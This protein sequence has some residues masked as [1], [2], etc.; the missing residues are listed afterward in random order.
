MSQSSLIYTIVGLP[1]LMLFVALDGEQGQR[2]SEAVGGAKIS[3]VLLLINDNVIHEDI[4]VMFC[5]YETKGKLS[6]HSY[7][8]CIHLD[9]NSLILLI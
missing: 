7:D 6:V 2:N 1:T 8:L 9:I 5:S 3:G 4:E